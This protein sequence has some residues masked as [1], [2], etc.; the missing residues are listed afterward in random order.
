MHFDACPVAQEQSLLDVIQSAASGLDAAA[1]ASAVLNKCPAPE[2]IDWL[3]AVME[4]CGGDV[5]DPIA[6]NRL[7]LKRSKSAKPPAPRKAT[8]KRARTSKAAAK[9]AELQAAELQALHEKLAILRVPEEAWP[10]EL[11][12]GNKN[13][14]IRDTTG[15]SCIEVQLENKTFRAMK[16]PGHLTVTVRNFAWIKLGGPDCA[17]SMCKLACGFNASADA[18][19]GG[20]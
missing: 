12:R 6:Q 16:W 4:M 17:W 2:P 13:Y 5:P 1:D 14:T 8:F 3:D 18:S 11:G 7:A 10:T 15:L 9:P 20:A 19:A